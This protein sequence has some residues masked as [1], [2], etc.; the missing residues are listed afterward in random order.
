MKEPLDRIDYI[1]KLTNNRSYNGFAKNIGIKS[2]QVFYDL[3]SGKVKNIS[4]D[5]G[6]AI[7]KKYGS[8]QLPWIL[9][10]EG[11][12]FVQENIKSIE[13][14]SSEDSQ[15]SAIPMYNFPVAAGDVETYIDPDDIKVVGHLNIPGAHKDSIA[16]PAYGDSMY[17]TLTNGDWAVSR[18]ITDPTEIM[19]GELYYI[20]W[21]DYKMYKRLLS[22]GNEDEVI[23]WSDNQLDKIGDRPKFA[24]I[25]IKKENIRKLRL[26]TEIL[27]KPNY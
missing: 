10:G 26:V 13:E 16:I 20:E 9:V 11:E 17:P 25:I 24:P 1:M 27:K 6:T 21:S 23:L 18:P 12:P 4:R 2:A 7:I 14:S 5:L 8:F 15:I 3:K 19:W 22:S